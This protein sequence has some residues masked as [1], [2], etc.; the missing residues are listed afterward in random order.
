ME[1]IEFLRGKPYKVRRDVKLYDD[2][3]LSFRWWFDFASKT[4][5]NPTAMAYTNIEDEHPRS[6]MVL[7]KYVDYKG[8]YFFSH[9]R[10]IDD[11][12]F[13]RCC[14]LFHW[15]TVD[16]QVI[17]NGHV[18]VA[19]NDIADQYWKTRNRFARAVSLISDQSSVLEK[20]LNF[21]TDILPAVPKADKRPDHWIGYLVEPYRMEFWQG[22]SHRL[23]VRTL[24]ERIPFIDRWHKGILSP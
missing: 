17:I 3:M 22:S 5:P 8:F 7:L 16:L 12:D 9:R 2:P 20:P 11:Q 1:K 13:G 19:D 14:L 4:E 24:Y 6:R 23:N 18:C 10:K 15:D 21:V